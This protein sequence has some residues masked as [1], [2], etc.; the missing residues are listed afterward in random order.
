M[1]V[2][3]DAPWCKADAEWTVVHKSITRS[4]ALKFGVKA[5]R[6]KLLQKYESKTYHFA[7]L[8]FGQREELTQRIQNILRG[9][10]FDVTVLKELL[11]NADDSKATK[12]YVVLDTRQHGTE[13]L[14][15]DEWKD[16]QGPALLVWN[17]SIFRNP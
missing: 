14:P 13:S 7:G 4:A 8:P 10:P 6:S 17:D 12:M 5:V 15:S 11:Q 2:F 16:L 9:Y 1:L 3:N